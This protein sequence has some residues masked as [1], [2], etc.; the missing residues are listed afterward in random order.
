MRAMVLESFG[1]A[2]SLPL[3]PLDVPRPEPGRGDVLIRVQYCGV[4][5][6]DLHTVEGDIKPPR[7]PVRL[8]PGRHGGL[9]AVTV[10]SEM[11]Q[12]LSRPGSPSVLDVSDRSTCVAVSS[13]KERVLNCYEPSL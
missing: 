4:C 6:T 3:R 8:A 10:F 5:H 12:G 7:L 11:V 2:E 1:S 13:L 9:V